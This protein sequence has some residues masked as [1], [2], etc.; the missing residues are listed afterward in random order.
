M[1]REH[2]FLLLAVVGVCATWYYN[3]QWMQTTETPSLNDFISKISLNFPSKSIGADI[4]CVVLTFFAWYIPD[5]IQLKIKYWWILIPLT[6]L[7]AIAFTFPLYL[8]MRERKL[9]LIKEK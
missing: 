6:F 1:K 2:L 8:F 4:I 5:A 9:R 7:V 3:I